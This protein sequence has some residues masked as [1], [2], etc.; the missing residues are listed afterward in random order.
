MMASS[1]SGSTDAVARPRSWSHEHFFPGT[2]KD[3][4]RHLGAARGTSFHGTSSAFPEIPP[5]PDL[6]L[7]RVPWP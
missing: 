2:R 7:F 4:L 5:F 1:L 6:Y 3:P